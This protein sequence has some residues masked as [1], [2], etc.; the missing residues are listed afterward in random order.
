MHHVF[1]NHKWNF[2]RNSYETS[3]ICLGVCSE[4]ASGF[5][6]MEVSRTCHTMIIGGYSCHVSKNV[7]IN[8][9]AKVEVFRQHTATFVFNLLIDGVKQSL[10]SDKPK[11][12]SESFL[13]KFVFIPGFISQFR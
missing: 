12:L 13:R 4:W 5:G 2:T 3:V 9:L 8:I 10:V 7:L 11:A 1:F 6:L